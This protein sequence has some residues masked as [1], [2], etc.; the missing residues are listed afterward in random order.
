MGKE[1]SCLGCAKKFTKSDASV[2]C[3]VCGLWIHCVCA[4]M[5]AD[6][7]DLIDKQKRDTGVTYWVCRSC[8]MYAQGMNHRLKQIEDE[9]KE[10]K[11]TASSN[12]EGLNSL[13]KKVEQIAEEVKK[14]KS[15]S[16]QEFEDRMREEKDEI[17]ERKDRELNIIVHGVDECDGE[18]TEREERM[19]WDE[20]K[21]ME[22][23][24][25]T[26]LRSGDIKFCR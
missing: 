8:T 6:V 16:R 13:E 22:L 18:V 12:K 19:K 21:F 26:N 17:R 10:V 7:F 3:T 4:D 20:Q 9:L 25:G 24:S 2:Q 1:T 5:S 23:L 11:Q 15:M 14:N